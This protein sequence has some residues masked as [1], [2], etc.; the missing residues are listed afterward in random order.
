MSEIFVI[1]VSG[2]GISG[3]QRQ[4]L[5]RCRTIVASSRYRHLAEGLA[6]ELIPIA[7]V[8]KALAAIRERLGSGEEGVL[9]SG[10]PLFFGI[11][12]TL[13]EEFGRD[14]VEIFPGL[15]AMQLACARFKIPW[16][17][18]GFVTLHGRGSEA[19][20]RLLRHPKLVIF[21]DDS[22][23]PNRLAGEFRQYLELVGA[24]KILAG[25]RIFVGENL[26][27]TNERL[28]E[29]TIAEIAARTF[30]PLN[31]MIFTRPAAAGSPGA[32]L[33]LREQELA[34]SRGLITKDEI[35]AVALH[36]LNL[37]REGVFWDLGAGSGSVSIE[38]ARLCPGLSIYAVEKQAEQLAN[39]RKNIVAFETFN[40]LP[41][42]GEA[43][44]VLGG[45]PD[46]DRVFIGGSG[47][48]LGGIIM[49]ALARL[50]KGGRITVNCVT[51]KTR[52][53]A[54]GLLAAG[55]CEVSASEV[56]VSRFAGGEGEDDRVELNPIT[57]V[58][59]IK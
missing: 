43:P 10:D 56:R 52:K 2:S 1:G 26:G 3:A 14:R 57:V 55:G 15:S 41:M 45:L 54:P 5:A 36:R 16:D 18:A 23:P 11:A 32:P 58:V 51:E 6:A 53:L 17:D 19:L 35:R 4:I 25:S 28:T 20:F 49:A 29:G 31:L 46:P 47:G 27:G 12:R 34:H 33:G 8:K 39:I 50:K 9:A 7:P 24:E 13:L 42:A 37:P 38:A 48:K 30:E 59:G 40:V 22:Q 21:T 44:E